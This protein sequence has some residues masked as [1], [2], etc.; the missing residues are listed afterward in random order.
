VKDRIFS[1]QD[2]E[3]ALAVA[4]ATLGLPPGDLRYVVLEAGT[5]GG[6]GLKPTLA[7]V[8]VLLQDP[9]SNAPPPGL[10]PP[11][12][13]GAPEVSVSSDPR[14]GLQATLR[15]VAEAGRLDLGAEVE[16]GEEAVIVHLSGADVDFFLGTDGKGEIFRALEHLLQRMYGVALQP[17]VLRLAMEG[18]RERRDA[19][20]ADEARRVAAEVR[21]DGLP[22]TLDPQNAY[23]RRVVH[24]ALQDEP[25]VTTF[26]VGEGMERRVTVAPVGPP[27]EGPSPGEAGDD[28]GD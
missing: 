6:R 25:G 14:E 13:R 5:P 12:R 24:L 15:A 23:E 18:F 27:A 21:G 20:L 19:A 1:G 11:G 16:E 26:S 9:G 7:R 17:R 2:V 22:R 28:R 8:A 3:D 10:P 4:A